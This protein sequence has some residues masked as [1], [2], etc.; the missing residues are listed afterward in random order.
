[1]DGEP[2]Q[3]GD[4]LFVPLRPF[5]SFLPGDRRDQRERDRERR[6][7]EHVQHGRERHR[8]QPPHRARGLSLTG[9]VGTA[10]AVA[11]EEGADAVSMRRVAREMRVGAMS[12]YWYVESKDDLHQLMVDRVQAEARPPEPSGD[13]RADLRAYARNMRGALLRHPWAIDFLGS[14]PPS[15]PNEASNAERLFGVF[16]GLGIDPVTVVW[17]AM[18]VGTYVMGAVLREVREI[19]WQRAADE[20]RA[21]MTEEE[22]A[23]LL[24][25][26]QRRVRESGRYPHLAAIIDSGVDPDA[27]ESR[28]E[29]FEFGLDCMLDG[30]EARVN[31]GFTAGRRES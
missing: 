22:I 13:W 21:S 8:T 25:D 31:A 23:G 5:R 1:M 10:I 2:D 9:I 3:C 19:R 20:V 4:E 30:I 27:P 12:L 11:D 26:F 14:G 7:A 28:D 15:G 16:D 18:T 6:I 17:V 29:R 24:A